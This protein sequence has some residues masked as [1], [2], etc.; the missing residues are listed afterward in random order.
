MR[1]KGDGV[2]EGLEGRGVCCGLGKVEVGGLPH[3]LMLIKITATRILPLCLSHYRPTPFPHSFSFSPSLFA[4]S[5]SL[6]RL[7]FAAL[8]ILRRFNLAHAQ[9]LLVL[10]TALAWAAWENHK[11]GSNCKK[12]V[13][14][15]SAVLANELL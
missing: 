6:S 11:T 13:M 15:G 12:G 2:F 5:L 1:R 4:L 3:H 7:A 10:P 14:A 9:V 8:D